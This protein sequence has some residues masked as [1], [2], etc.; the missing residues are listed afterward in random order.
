MLNF[1]GVYLVFRFIG[2]SFKKQANKRQN[3]GSILLVSS[4]SPQVTLFLG[5]A[6]DAAFLMQMIP[7][8]FLSHHG[9]TMGGFI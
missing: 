2:I 8:G 3:V 5:F 9:K 1:R 7:L 6:K 4:F